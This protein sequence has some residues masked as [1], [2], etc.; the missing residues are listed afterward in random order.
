MSYRPA[1]LCQYRQDEYQYCRVTPAYE[2][3]PLRIKAVRNKQQK[4][5]AVS[6]QEDA[7]IYLLPLI[8]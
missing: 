1:G 7:A 2:R 6:Y 3:Q 4:P 5:K 8:T